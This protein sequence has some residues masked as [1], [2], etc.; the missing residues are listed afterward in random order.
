VYEVG[1]GGAVAAALAGEV[2]EQHVALRH[3]GVRVF[4]PAVGTLHA[5]ARME[6]DER[7]ERKEEAEEL[8]HGEIVVNG[9]IR[10]RVNGWVRG[11]VNR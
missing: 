10:R 1:G 2:D 11:Q 6:E 5:V 9:G 8:G 4:A 3:D 7:E